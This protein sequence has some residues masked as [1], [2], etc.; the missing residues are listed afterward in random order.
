M[1]R[2][3]ILNQII[4]LLTITFHSVEAQKNKL[5]HWD[6]VNITQE[7][8]EKPRASFDIYPDIQKAWKDE[9]EHSGW[10]QSLNGKW[11]FQFYQNPGRRTE[12][13]YKTTFKDE[14]WDL[15][16]VPS[17]WELKGYG[18]PIYSN[19]RYPFD[20]SD[21]RTPKE[22]N[23]TAAYRR[24]FTIPENW[25]DRQVFLTFEGVSSAFSLWVNGEKVGYSQDS[26]TP[27]EFNITKFLASSGPNVIGVEVY[28][29][30]DGSYLEDQD[31]WR[32]SGIFRDVYL[33]SS[34]ENHIRDFS[35]IADLNENYTQ[36]IFQLSFE[37]INYLKK[38]AVVSVDYELY[39]GNNSIARGVK[40]LKFSG[41][42]ISSFEPVNINGIK[43]W[44][45][46]TP[47]LY[48]LMI[49]LRKD[50]EKIIEVIP[51]KVGFRKIEMTDGK[52]LVNGQAVRFKG[53]NRHELSHENGYT[54]SREEMLRDIFLMK[55]H[56]INSVRTSH[57]PNHPL[58]YKL[59]DQYGLYVIDEANIETHGFGAY[60]GNKL[61]N[62]PEWTQAYVDR[63]KRM[64]IRDRNHPSIIFW[65]IG[66]ES[67]DGLNIKAAYDWIKDHDPSRLVHYEGAIHPMQ[68]DNAIEENDKKTSDVRSWMYATP[69]ECSNW[70]EKRPDVPLILCEYTHAMGNSNGNLKAYW[71]LI[72]AENNFQGAFVWDWA[73]Q[74]LAQ[75]IPEQYKNVSDQ[76][77][78]LAYGGWWEDQ[79]GIYNDGNFCM[80]GIVSADRKVRPGLL[81]LKYYHQF[82]AV[83][84]KNWETLT[85]S[86]INRFD[87]INL[88]EMLSAVWQIID[89][90]G[91]V[92]SGEINGLAILPGEQFE[93][94]I[95]E[96]K[97]PNLEG[98][99]Y[100]INFR[101]F[102]RKEMPFAKEG[103]ELAFEQ[104]RL[105]SSQYAEWPKSTMGNLKSFSN[106]RHFTVAGDN[107]SLVFNIHSGQIETYSV[108][109]KTVISQ[110]PKIE[111][112][113]SITDNDLGAAI[114][115]KQ[116][117]PLIWS[118]AN[119]YLLKTFKPIV[120]DDKITIEFLAEIPAIDAKIEMSYRVYPNG[121][122]DVENRFIPEGEKLPKFMPRFG[123]QLQLAPGFEMV[124]WFGRGPEATYVDRETAAV[125]T[126][127]A[128]VDELWIE[129][130]RPQENNNRS[131]TRW[132]EFTDSEGYGI[133]IQ[134][135]PIIDFSAS[136][137]RIEDIQNSRYQFQVP[138]NPLIFVMIDYGQS[139]VGGYDSWSPKGLPTPEFRLETKE[140]NYRYRI[141]PLVKN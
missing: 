61:N 111:F 108:F 36:G 59:C 123:N 76:E 116:Y 78:F 35:V 13:F 65:S 79:Y 54:V 126:Y 24:Q 22:D 86:I 6:N 18:V 66:N 25:K 124:K 118:A 17:N 15:I 98:N 72:Y 46:E 102:T 109:G 10:Y 70:I 44:N 57:Y 96:D 33:W 121:N 5:P 134:G 23:P 92:A 1:K 129:Y 132:V 139:G 85:F 87:F 45:A 41:N 90:E 3:L 88:E 74:G 122:I 91:L 131:S 80:N 106:G 99:E 127:T 16:D 113:R 49:T 2:A 94:S 130:A 104:F 38:Q 119:Q 125:G 50:S 75:P 14:S 64:L 28:R 12:G 71:D 68:D 53:V 21:L 51:V 82:V 95:P 29:W 63:V 8:A 77:T 93:F 31:F 11:R 67:G 112:R 110:G 27:A 141:V 97:L 34:A 73:D 20:I 120:E 140:I 133:K 4:F 52:I 48:T 39:D 117:S 103:Y 114:A 83:Q 101:F 30:S 56:N 115:N 26:R 138:R 43:K 60:G 89:E 137:F 107:F 55:Q 69:E 81:A 135:D 7:N 47:N 136:H 62:N 32:L 37:L 58:W 19:V 100:F 84:P 42:E 128:T 9:P 105:P 40:E